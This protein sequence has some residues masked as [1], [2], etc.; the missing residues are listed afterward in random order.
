MVADDDY[1]ICSPKAG[2]HYFMQ[3][4]LIIAEVDRHPLFLATIYAIR[5][6]KYFGCI[7]IKMLCFDALDG[8]TGYPDVVK[9]MVP[10]PT[11]E[12]D[13]PDHLFQATKIKQVLEQEYPKYRHER[14]K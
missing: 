3:H 13:L 4:N 8:I 14:P 12:I 2:R 7:N 6:A 1:K 5:I 10:Y 9:K 11:D